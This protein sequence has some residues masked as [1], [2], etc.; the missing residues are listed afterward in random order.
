MFIQQNIMT[1]SLGEISH[2][3]VDGEYQLGLISTHCGLTQQENGQLTIKVV[4]LQE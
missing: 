4:V 3:Q 2:Y 1:V